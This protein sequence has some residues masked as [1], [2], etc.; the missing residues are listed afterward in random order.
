MPPQSGIQP[1][2]LM[3]PNAAWMLGMIDDPAELEM[4]MDQLHL[5]ERAVVFIPVNDS[6]DPS[7]VGTGSHWSLL[8]F[9]RATSTFYY[10][11]S[12]PTFTGNRRRAEVYAQNI[13]PVLKATN[14]YDFVVLKVPTQSNGFD[15]GI[16][17]ISYTEF[18]FNWFQEHGFSSP[19]QTD[20]VVKEMAT[21]ITKDST[22]K[23]RSRLVALIDEIAKDKCK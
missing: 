9:Y 20:E 14:Q 1:I 21:K 11:D 4:C 7:K 13:Y 3:N 17:V 22:A 16:F 6:E 10:L 23:Q 19:L 8:V 5:S 18:L 12:S 2:L 15:C